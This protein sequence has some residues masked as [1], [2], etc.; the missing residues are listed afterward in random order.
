MSKEAFINALNHI[1]YDLV[2]EFVSE[3]ERAQKRIRRKKNIMRLAPLAACFVLITCVGTL[4]LLGGGMLGDAGSMPPDNKTDDWG[5][6]G[7]PPLTGMPEYED[8]LTFEYNGEQYICYIDESDD[9]ISGL[10]KPVPQVEVG[11]YIGKVEVKHSNGSAEA[12]KIYKSL[13]NNSDKLIIETKDGLF[14]L[15]EIS[16]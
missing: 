4:F 16:D 12:L 10:T 14:Y 11:A 5:G 7:D 9:G 3:K 6:E 13:G 8:V 2:E 1:D 15:A